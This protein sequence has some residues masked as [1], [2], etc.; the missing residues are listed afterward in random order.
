[1]CTYNELAALNFFHRCNPMLE[2]L[3]CC[4]EATHARGLAFMKVRVRKLTGIYS[5]M[6]HVVKLL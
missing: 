3:H 2:I 6:G 4:I 1:M 5:A